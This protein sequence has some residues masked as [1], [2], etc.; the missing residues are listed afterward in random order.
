MSRVILGEMSL[1]WC[2]ICDLPI[3][4]QR[5]CSLCGNST[6]PV[7]HT[8]PGDIRPAFEEDVKLIRDTIGTQ[9]GIPATEVL[10]HDN[11]LVV[12]NNVP[13]LD[14]MDEIIVHGW[15]LGNIR[16]DIPSDRYVFIPNQ[17]GL[18]LL[19]DCATSN[20]VVV[21][22]GAIPFIERGA[23]CLVPGIRKVTGDF[24]MDDEVLVTDE[25]GRIIMSGTAQMDSRRMLAEKRGVGV[26]SR[27]RYK[28]KN[29][30]LPSPRIAPTWSR[31]VEAN[32]RVLGK[33]VKNA[34]RFI[35]KTVNSSDL[36]VAVSYSGGKDSLASL[37]LV[38]EAGFKPDILFV[39]TGIEL[40]ETIENVN[41]I[42]KKYSLN[43]VTIDVGDAFYRALEYF[44]PPA[45][46]F[47]WCC[48]ICKL[49]P[50]VRLINKHYPTGILSFIGQR[51]Y[52]SKQR[53]EKGNK[54]INPWVPNQEGAS[55]IQKWNALTVWLY[56]FSRNAPYNPWYEH[57]LERIGCW[58]C[59]A[60][61]VADL[62]RI[63]EGYEGSKRFFDFIYRWAEEKGYSKKW[64]DMGLWRWRKYPGTVKQLLKEV[65][66]DETMPSPTGEASVERTGAA[67]FS[68]RTEKSISDEDTLTIEGNFGRE[69]SLAE[70]SKLA[71]ILG[72]V[73]EQNRDRIE[74]GNASEYAIV[75]RADSLTVK[76]PVHG[77]KK[78]FKD[79]M[80]IIKRAIN[81][82]GCGVCTGRCPT[83]ALS[84]IPSGEGARIELDVSKCTGC[85]KC[86][87]PCPIENFAPR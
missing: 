59:P 21:D 17:Y 37:L 84:L 56:L 48:K 52:E 42:V 85:R 25:H 82:L 53:K 16:Y 61:D 74:I 12:L 47:R 19:R 49:G 13:S 72:E 18:Y 63:K 87:G 22:D 54:W 10:M 79:A 29:Y 46:D 43:L 41:K 58:L 81:C 20:I 39:N 50:A 55:P 75:I 11:A 7:A 27:R 57:G 65:G 14:L 38:L 77:V 36:P 60:S 32:E 30:P 70:V 8:P 24:R 34:K 80:S 69:I 6:S 78:N 9:F 45:K 86:M 76:G 64:V 67:A 44:G 62:K 71:P 4:G 28:E 26:K 2:G 83:G 5:V 15:A 23:N 31:A 33:K 66:G 1:R 35:R 51:Q 3:V 68:A 40:P 73:K